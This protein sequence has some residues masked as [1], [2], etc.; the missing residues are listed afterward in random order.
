MYINP[1]EEEVPLSP[2]YKRSNKINLI[3]MQLYQKPR[4]QFYSCGTW[5]P[6]MSLQHESW[7]SYSHNWKFI[8]CHDGHWEKTQ[9]STHFVLFSVGPS[10]NLLLA[11]FILRS[12]TIQSD[13]SLL[14]RSQNTYST[15]L[16]IFN[17][18]PCIRLMSSWKVW[19][20]FFLSLG[21]LLSSRA[22]VHFQFTS[23]YW[24]SISDIL[25][26]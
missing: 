18:F 6:S 7:F 1:R 23:V 13:N 21:G 2:G 11:L 10:S 9:R 5:W 20:D 8:L 3:P 25:F 14:F 15:Y 24:D 12:L 19:K 26:L 17:Y 22:T 4:S 16:F